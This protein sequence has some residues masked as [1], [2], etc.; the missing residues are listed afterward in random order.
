MSAHNT[1]MPIRTALLITVLAALLPLCACSGAKTHRVG[2]LVRGVKPSGETTPI[3]GVR[4]T[5][6]PLGLSPVPLPV[7]KDTITELS[8]SAGDAT[9]TD[10]LGRVVFTLS[11][12]HDYRIGVQPPIAGVWSDHSDASFLL[13]TALSL[14]ELNTPTDSAWSIEIIRARDTAPE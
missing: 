3:R 1:H 14:R 2:L 8:L 11:A 12:E 4:V 9:F 13:D 10:T 5:A 6:T 7:N